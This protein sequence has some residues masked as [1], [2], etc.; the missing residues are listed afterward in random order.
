MLIKR[1][2]SGI[3]LAMLLLGSIFIFPRPIVAV[4]IA[5]VI[6]VG[7]W[8]FYIISEIKGFKPFKVYG[9]IIGIALCVITFLAASGNYSVYTDNIILLLLFIAI[10]TVLGKY[11]FKKDGSSVIANSAVTFLGILYVSF[12]FTFMIK[13][14]YSFD[15]ELGKGLVIALVLIT[16]FSDISAYFCGSKWGRH[17]LIPRISAKKTIEGSIAGIAGSVLVS[18]ILKF[19]FLEFMNCFESVVLGILLSVVGQIGDL[20]ESLIKRD[21]NVKDSGQFVPGL[22]GV[23]DFMDS[24]LFTGPVMYIFLICIGL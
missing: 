7:L 4:I 8:E 11:A 20:I 1:T 12:L 6:G 15:P 2:I 13:L 22:G 9:V 3:V 18:L 14:R 5:L 17:K 21:A 24:L 19:W 16:K 10:V 23:L